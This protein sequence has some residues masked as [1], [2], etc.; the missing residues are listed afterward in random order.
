MPTRGS[1]VS[2][3]LKAVKNEA[4]HGL[5]LVDVALITVLVAVV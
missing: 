3:V 1:L 2:L 4:Q 5:D